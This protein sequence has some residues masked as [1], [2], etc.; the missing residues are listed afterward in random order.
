ME[1]REFDEQDALQFIRDKVGEDVSALC[2]DD[3]LLLMIDTMLDFYETGDDDDDFDPSIEQVSAWVEK[4]LRRDKECRLPLEH[5]PALVA[6]ELEY[7][8]TLFDL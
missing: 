8:D 7:E 3:D 4:Q 1:I 2:D 5:L 6:A